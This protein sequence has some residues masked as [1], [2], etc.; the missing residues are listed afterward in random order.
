MKR[1]ISIRHYLLGGI[2]QNLVKHNLHFKEISLE[3]EIF[4]YGKCTTSAIFT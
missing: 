1:S 4:K 3:L 2:F